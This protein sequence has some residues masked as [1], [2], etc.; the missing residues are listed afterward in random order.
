MAQIADK[1]RKVIHLD[2]TVRNEER[3]ITVSQNSGIQWASCNKHIQY[4]GYINP[5][6]LPSG[7]KGGGAGAPSRI[8]LITLMVLVSPVFLVFLP[9][10]IIAGVVVGGVAVTLEGLNVFISLMPDNVRVQY[11]KFEKPCSENAGIDF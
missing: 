2:K 3:F 7:G 1:H 11:V 4:P 6:I 8:I 10:I 9:Q 5:G